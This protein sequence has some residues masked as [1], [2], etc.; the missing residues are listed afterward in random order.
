MTS[1]K[2]FHTF[3]TDAHCVRLFTIY[4]TQDLYKYLADNKA[5][6]MILG[7]GSNVLF[8][9]D[10]DG[11]VLLNRIKG[12]EVVDEDDN[13]LLVSLGSGEIWHN[14]VMWSVG[15]GLWGV[16][17]LALIP[18]TVGAAPMQNIG[19]YGV[20]QDKTFHS[21]EAIDLEEGTRR[22]FYKEECG[23]GYRD[24]YFKKEGKQKYFITKVSYLL[25]KQP[26]PV[27]GYADVAKRLEGKK[28]TPKAIAG[29]IIDIRSQKLPDPDKI[30]N[31]GSFFKNPVVEKNIADKLKVDYPTL[32]SYPAGNHVK[33][34]AGWL[35]EQCGFKGE[36]KGNTG[37]YVNQ[38]LV[39]V[40]HGQASGNEIYQYAASI[41]EAVKEKFGI[42][43]E[44][45]VNIIRN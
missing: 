10:F 35:I 4:S 8:S 42:D 45:E 15:H 37:T 12:I 38:A 20:E 11:D 1:L 23:F 36:V 27:L 9:G 39:L 41:S 14:F 22:V 44:M 17:N 34:A 31:A 2:P 3:A 16:E 19:A 26:D 28:I 5:N 30:G 21:L 7:G 18:G 32:P 6:F 40:N 43:L 13:A 29:E 25:S 24:S 33:I